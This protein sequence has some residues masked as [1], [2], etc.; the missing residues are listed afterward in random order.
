MSSQEEV[1]PE[2]DQQPPVEA[3]G[4]AASTNSGPN[5]NVPQSRGYRKE[6][7]SDST[8]ILQSFYLFR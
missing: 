3:A 6:N 8:G 2:V 7:S 4:R 1:E 5:N